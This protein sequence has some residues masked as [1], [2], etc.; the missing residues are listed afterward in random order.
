[1][2]RV[3]H[4]KITIVKTRRPAEKTINQELPN[5]FQKAEFLLE[6]GLLDK[7]VPRTMMRETLLNILKIHLASRRK[8]KKCRNFD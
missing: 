5:G 1:M 7:I 2:I 4:Q 8:I 3:Y 6:H